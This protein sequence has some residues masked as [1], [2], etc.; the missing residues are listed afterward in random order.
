MLKISKSKIEM[1]K[2]KFQIILIYSTPLRQNLKRYYGTYVEVH[3][4]IYF[5]LYHGSRPWVV[6]PLVTPSS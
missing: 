4:N 3:G 5:V 6:K 1:P 2:E